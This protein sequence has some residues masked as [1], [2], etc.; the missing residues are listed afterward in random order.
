MKDL[1]PSYAAGTLGDTDRKRVRTHLA[2]CPSC[3]ADLAAWQ[4]IA[5]AVESRPEAPAR[6]VRAALTRSA[7]EGPVERDGRPIRRHAG[8]VIAE[9]RLIRP[10]VPISSALVMALGV[11]FTSLQA[12]TAGLMLSLIAPIVAAAG[13]AGT[14]RSGKDELIAA[15]PTS[16]RLLLLIRLVLVF[17][18]DLVLALTASATL[19]A[20]GTAGTTSLNAL[21][22]AWLGPMALLSSLSLLI[23]VR[24]GP[25]V[26]LGVAVGL[27][28]LRV[29]AGG[30]L[31]R[32]GWA[33]GLVLQAWSTTAPVLIASA[34]IAAVAIAVGSEPGKGRH[35]THPM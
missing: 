22:G 5:D 13:I 30:V 21:V 18:Y 25:D 8:L 1:L 23:A 6:V 9:A 11:A 26:A 10:P 34:A 19:T 24:L 16:S 33:G 17:G 15:T 4:V 29:L 32:D 28:A 35:A 27:W 31:A 12:G 14:Y 3:R 2:D 20:T 7:F